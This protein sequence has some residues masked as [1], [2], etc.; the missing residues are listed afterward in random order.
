MNPKRWP[1]GLCVLA[2]TLASAL[3]DARAQGPDGR[4]YAPGPFDRLDIAGAGSV[5]LVQADRDEVFVKGDAQA[6][7]AVENNRAPLQSE[8]HRRPCPILG[9]EWERRD[10]VRCGQ[11]RSLGPAARL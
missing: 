9:A 6:Q 2:F 1:H 11:E 8:A 10:T 3:G 4:L 5:R 7:S